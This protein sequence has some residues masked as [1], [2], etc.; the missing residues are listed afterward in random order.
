MWP[1]APGR[2]EGVFPIAVEPGNGAVQC[3]DDLHCTGVGL[4]LF[5]QAFHER[6]PSVRWWADERQCQRQA[7]RMMRGIRGC[8]KL[9][10]SSYTERRAS[11][12]SWHP[13][14]TGVSRIRV[15]FRKL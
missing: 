11:C 4:A 6:I 10:G 5:A 1:A 9:L 15:T 14:F 8:P 3:V 2:G 13:G 7:E 12:Q